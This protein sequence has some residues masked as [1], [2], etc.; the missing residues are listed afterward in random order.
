MACFSRD[1]AIDETALN[2]DSR[3]EDVAGQDLIYQPLYTIDGYESACDR[4]IKGTAGGD[5][6]WSL[7]LTSVRHDD[8]TDLGHS[9]SASRSA[10][11]FFFFFSKSSSSST[12]ETHLHFDGS[13]WKQHTQITLAMKGPAQVFNITAGLW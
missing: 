11:S 7:D 10:N 2:E 6:S 13:D 4:W 8:W 12:E 1:Y 5:T 3:V 9:R